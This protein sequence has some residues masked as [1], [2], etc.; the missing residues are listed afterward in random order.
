MYIEH[1]GYVIEDLR[2]YRQPCVTIEEF[3]SALARVEESVKEGYFKEDRISMVF[4]S[5]ECVLKPYGIGNSSRWKYAFTYDGKELLNKVYAMG[6]NLVTVY[7]D[8][9]QHGGS[10]TTLSISESEEYEGMVVF[11]HQYL[12]DGEVSALVKR[13]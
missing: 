4:V 5:D 6:G 3:E 11:V 10:L 7:G 12:K 13:S 1:K 9:L 8:L 2:V